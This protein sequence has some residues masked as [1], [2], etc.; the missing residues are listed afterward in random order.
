[1]LVDNQSLGIT[2]RVAVPNTCGLWHT[3]LDSHQVI[4]PWQESWSCLSRAGINIR[5]PVLTK[6]LFTCV[7]GGNHSSRNTCPGVVSQRV[8]DH[9]VHCGWTTGAAQ[10]FTYTSQCQDPSRTAGQGIFL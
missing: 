7:G 6:R 4:H 9:H 1:M 8:F 2:E 5:C 10:E 3:C